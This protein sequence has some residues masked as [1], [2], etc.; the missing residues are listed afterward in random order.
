MKL[1]SDK[2]NYPR[3]LLVGLAIVA[4]FIVIAIYLAMFS[5]YEAM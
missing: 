2:L 4:G 5:M 3:T 1:R